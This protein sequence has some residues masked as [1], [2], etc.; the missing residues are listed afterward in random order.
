MCRIHLHIGF[1]DPSDVADTDDEFLRVRNEIKKRFAEL[2]ITQ[3][4]KRNI[5]NVLSPIEI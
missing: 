3:I 5:I 1:D 2:L 4:L